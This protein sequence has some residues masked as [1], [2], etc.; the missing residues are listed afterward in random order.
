MPQGWHDFWRDEIKTLN[1]DSEQGLL[2]H[3]V[4]R[5]RPGRQVTNALMT[6]ISYPNFLGFS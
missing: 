4:G 3:A 6:S 5:Q 2:D 1:K